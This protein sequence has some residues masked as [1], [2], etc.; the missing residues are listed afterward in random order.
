V[1]GD[2]DAL[3]QVFLIL[4]DNALAHTSSGA[5]IEVTAAAADKCV[6]TSVR[7]DGTGIAPDALPHIFERFYRGQVSRSGVGAGLGL[8][9]AKELVT[10]QGGSITVESEVGQ[11]SVFT[12]TL[13]Q[14]QTSET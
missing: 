12:V 14:A 7:D 10:A 6:M 5:T 2:R 11:G 3:K 9:I 4:L 13:P 8:S 1:L